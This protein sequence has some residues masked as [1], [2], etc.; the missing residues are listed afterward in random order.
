MFVNVNINEPVTLQTP[1]ATLLR[2]TTASAMLKSKL[3]YCTYTWTL[4][5]FQWFDPSIVCNRVPDTV[6]GEVSNPGDIS[7]ICFNTRYFNIHMS[8]NN[9][10]RSYTCQQTISRD[11]TCCKD[12]TPRWSCAAAPWWSG[13]T[14]SLELALCLVAEKSKIQDQFKNYRISLEISGIIFLSLIHIWRCR[15]LL[16]CRSRWSPYH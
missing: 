15:R 10:Q 7:K 2:T 1:K 6:S 5:Y 3:E 16:T 8:T 14:P 4:G 13:E 12:S 11:L 9:F